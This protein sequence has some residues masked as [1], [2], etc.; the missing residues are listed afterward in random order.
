MS[1]TFNDLQW[2]S[3]ELHEQNQSNLGTDFDK[4]PTTSV[5]AL[6]DHNIDL[7]RIN[8]NVKYFEIYSLMSSR[9]LCP[10]I[11]KPTRVTAGSETLIG[12]IWCN[13]SVSTSFGVILYDTSDHF[14]VFSQV[15]ELGD[16]RSTMIPSLLLNV[17]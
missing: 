12:Q 9:G 1:E 16:F 14:P 17:D 6:G 2:Q 5:Y 10:T 7:L 13:T 3:R 4:F 11:F 8:S 15:K